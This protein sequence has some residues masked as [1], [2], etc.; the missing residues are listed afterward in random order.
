GDR[1]ADVAGYAVDFDGVDDRLRVDP[2]ELTG[3][4]ELTVSALVDLDAVPVDGRIV[5]KASDD[6]N[7]ILELMAATTGELVGRLSL[8]GATVEAR[9]GTVPTGGWHHLAMVW[10]GATL[11]LFID[12]AE[13]VS[14]PAT[15][16]I[17][18]GPA[19]PFTIGD[20]PTGGG[21]VDGRIS[22]V[23]VETV[24]RSAAWLAASTSNQRNPGSFL[25]VGGV[26][27][28]TWLDQGTWSYRK[29]IQ[30]ESDLVPSDQTSYP[31]LIQI[32]DADLAAGAT[33]NGRDVVITAA[34]GTT[35][36][37]H[38]VEAWNPATGALSIWALI[39]VLSS[40]TDTDLYL[41]YGNT[42]ADAQDDP[43]AVFGPDAD[44]VLTGEP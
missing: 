19:M 7:R 24:A 39:P 44:L 14:E 30:V 16:S 9:G 29:R 3:A 42:S 35:R 18:P 33:T 11:R 20:L 12:G 37:D 17:D 2:F 22:E 15:G 10:D 27:T 4:R 13:V 41:Y 40:S 38:L 34:D 8:D 5:A 31:L 32:T 23:R 43:Q 25:S 28:G 21:A 26:Q 36:L 6:T 1:V